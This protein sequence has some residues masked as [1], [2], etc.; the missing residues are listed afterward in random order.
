VATFFD[1][2]QSINQVAGKVELESFITLKP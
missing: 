2:P 1:V